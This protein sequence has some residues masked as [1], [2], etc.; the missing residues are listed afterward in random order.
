[1]GVELNFDETVD[2]LFKIG[3]EELQQEFYNTEKPN[4]EEVKKAAQKFVSEYEKA[5]QTYDILSKGRTK[6]SSRLMS[7]IE[8]E[9]G[10]REAFDDFQNK[11]NLYYNQMVKVMYVWMDRSSGKVTLSAID[12][13][14]SALA[15]SKYG[16]VEY[17][18][19]E[20]KNIFEIEDYDPAFLNAA[21]QSIY[22]RWNIARG[23]Y[24][25]NRYLP[26]L[27]QINGVWGGAKVNN[28]GTI[29]EAYVNFYLNKYEFS[30]FL[31]QDV[32]IYILHPTYGA[33]AVDNASGFLIGDTSIGNIQFAVKKET[34]SPMNLK[35]VYNLTQEILSEEV[36][37]IDRFWEVFHDQELER[38][39]TEGKGQAKQI[40]GKDLEEAV[41]NLKKLYEL[42]IFV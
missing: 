20:L 28:L 3:T 8:L 5:N 27:W 29:A 21:E 16:S 34:A 7:R 23:R 26:I 6:R 41:D 14:I 13:N 9:E 24:R 32:A 17:R 31:G 25:N 39:Q 1:M 33:V 10:A 38:V 42:K 40:I 18:L 36:F 19:K 15:I 35:K 11:I 12:N 37:N 22:A 4:I 2:E 30:K